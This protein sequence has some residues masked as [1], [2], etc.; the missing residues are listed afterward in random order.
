M[1]I[2]DTTMVVYQRDE[3]PIDVKHITYLYRRYIIDSYVGW[4]FVYIYV[5][6]I[7]YNI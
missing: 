1:N 7:I 6:I 3:I 2:N 5:F 4:F